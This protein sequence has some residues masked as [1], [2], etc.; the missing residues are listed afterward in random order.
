MQIRYVNIQLFTIALRFG[1]KMYFMV[2]F[3]VIYY[4]DMYLLAND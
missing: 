2:L 3:V 4:S 1:P